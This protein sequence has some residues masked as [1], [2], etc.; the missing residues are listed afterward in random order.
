MA[1][2]GIEIEIEIEIAAQMKRKMMPKTKE[3]IVTDYYYW[4]CL[5][6]IGGVSWR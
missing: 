2:I 4:S 6:R 5:E 3:Q 1:V